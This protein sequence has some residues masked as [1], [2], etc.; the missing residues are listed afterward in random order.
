MAP[1]LL[2][3]LRAAIRTRHM[4]PKTEQAYVDWTRRFVR[5]HRLRHPREL[6]VEDVYAFLTHSRSIA[7]YSTSTFLRDGTSCGPGV[8]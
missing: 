6:G 5:F 7:T 1:R 4:S 2:D 8:P 3:V